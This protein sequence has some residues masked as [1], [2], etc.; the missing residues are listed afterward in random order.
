MKKAVLFSLLLAALIALGIPGAAFAQGSS[1]TIAISCV[2]P[3]IPGVNAPLI[4]GE[5][6]NIISSQTETK[7][8]AEETKPQMPEMIQESASQ[9]QTNNSGE[10][11]LVVVKTLYSR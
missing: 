3:A 9:A 10:K 8:K 6:Q 4:E 2:I 7:A 5:T 1:H 11:A